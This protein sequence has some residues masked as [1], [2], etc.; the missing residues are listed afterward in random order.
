MTTSVTL[1]P[2]LLAQAAE[3]G[4]ILGMLPLLLIGAVFFLMM[5]PQQKRARMHRELVGSIKQGDKVVAAGGIVGTIR[6]VDDDL[7]VLQI[8]ENVSVK[9]D[10]TSVTRKLQN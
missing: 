3:G 6:R 7:L 5:R 1:T 8:A 4:G 2:M 10:R 9:V